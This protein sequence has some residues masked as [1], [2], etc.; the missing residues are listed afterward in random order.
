[1]DRDDPEVQIERIAN[2]LLGDP[3]M[4]PTRDE[5]AMFLAYSA[6]LLSCA[7]TGASTSGATLYCTTFPCHNCAKHIIAAGISRVVYVE[8]Y[9]KSKAYVL[10]SDALCLEAQT[11]DNK[12]V[13]FE[14][15]IGVGPRHFM[16]LFSL[17]GGNTAPKSR[18]DKRT[19]VTIPFDRKQAS[20]R[21]CLPPISYLE[22]EQLATL[23]LPSSTGG[24]NDAG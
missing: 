6:A 10:H 1:M 16:D 14:P 15:F 21:V 23:D 2:A 4:T 3:H 24:E 8:P 9:A 5:H 12:K 17:Q 22:L 11:T 7:R 19:G 13:M 18:K 20:L